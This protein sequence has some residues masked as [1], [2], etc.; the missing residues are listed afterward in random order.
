MIVCFAHQRPIFDFGPLVNA[1]FSY[2]KIPTPCTKN[3]NQKYNFYVILRCIE[4]MI[5]EIRQIV[6]IPGTSP[7]I[8]E[9]PIS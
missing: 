4:D 3:M 1:K 7:E 5:I 9:T 2:R 6:H 8:Y